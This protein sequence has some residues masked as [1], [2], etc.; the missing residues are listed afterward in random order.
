MMPFS[1]LGFAKIPEEQGE[2]AAQEALA[3]LS[4]IPV[5]RLPVVANREWQLYENT[6]L[7]RKAGIDLPANLRSRAK[8]YIQGM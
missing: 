8:K 7:L 5:D 2:W 4:G 3:I 6:M 1:M